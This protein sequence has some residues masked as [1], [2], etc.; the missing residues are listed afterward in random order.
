MTEDTAGNTWVTRF[1][2]LNKGGTFKAVAVVLVRKDIQMKAPIE[3]V[4]VDTALAFNYHR[5][6]RTGSRESR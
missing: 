4:A 1:K 6:R 5:R 3:M 2:Y